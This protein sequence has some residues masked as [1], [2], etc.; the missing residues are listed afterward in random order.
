MRLGGRDGRHVDHGSALAV[1]TCRAGQQAA[2][3]GGSDGSGKG[4][5]VAWA[6][7]PVSATPRLAC[8]LL[9]LAVCVHSLAALFQFLPRSTSSRAR[10]PHRRGQRRRGRPALAPRHAGTQS[11]RPPWRGL[12][13]HPIP[14]QTPEPTG[15]KGGRGMGKQQIGNRLEGSGS[16]RIATWYQHSQALLGAPWEG[17]RWCWPFPSPAPTCSTLAWLRVY[18]MCRWSSMQMSTRAAAGADI[19]R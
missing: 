12:R 10:G 14:G 18:R 15:S 16:A 1:P 19:G 6:Q 8:S 17:P 2:R 5:R 13:C 7:R 9:A 4:S 3:Q 11:S